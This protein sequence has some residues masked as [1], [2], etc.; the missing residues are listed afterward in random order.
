MTMK[1]SKIL[2]VHNY[3]Y[4]N[5]VQGNLYGLL[6]WEDFD[7]V[8]EYISNADDHSW[9][10][11]EI[12]KPL[13]DSA[14]SNVERTEFVESLNSCIHTQY[15][16]KHCGIAFVDSIK[17]PSI[18]KVFNPKLLKSICNIYGSSPIHGWVISRIKPVNLISSSDIDITNPE[19]HYDFPKAKK[20]LDAR[21][22]GC[23]LPIINTCRELETLQGGDLLEIMTIEPGAVK[24]VSIICDRTGDKMI[25][26][27]QTYKGYSIFVEKSG[28]N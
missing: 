3:D 20:T 19:K 9:F 14:T 17:S 2:E 23:P 1:N 27:Y 24:D 12:D 26:T 25:S 11:Y 22:T 18:L 28:A 6:S 21:K 5:L 8:C 10:I 4:I 13:P 16:R 15:S 7:R